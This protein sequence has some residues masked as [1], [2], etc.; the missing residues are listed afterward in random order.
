[1][2]CQSLS[3]AKRVPPPGRGSNGVSEM[4]LDEEDTSFVGGMGWSGRSCRSQIRVKS[5]MHG[6]GVVIEMGECYI[7]VN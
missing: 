3:Q 2:E 6:G 1:M 5:Y 4:D 7:W